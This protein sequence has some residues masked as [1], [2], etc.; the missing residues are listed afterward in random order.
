MRAG[1]PTLL[2]GALPFVAL[3]LAAGCHTNRPEQP[4]ERSPIIAPPPKAP[5]AP[6]AEGASATSADAETVDP[7]PLPEVDAEPNDSWRSAAPLKSDIEAQGRLVASDQ[8]WWVIEVPGPTLA[9][10]ELEGASDVDLVLEWMDPRTGHP[11]ARG[12]VQRGPGAETLERLKLRPP[13]AWLRVTEARGQVSRVPY[14]LLARL[15]PPSPGADAEP[16]DSARDA[17]PLQLGAR[18]QGT[19]GRVGDVDVWNID[20]DG[21]VHP[22]DAFRVDLGG[23]AGLRLRARAR[24]SSSQSPAAEAAGD[25]GR[26]VSLRRLAAPTNRTDALLVSVESRSGALPG[27]TYTLV[28]AREAPMAGRLGETEPNGSAELAQLVGA[29]G[30]LAG[31]L[32]APSDRDWYEISA[33]DTLQVLDLTLEPPLDRT[34]RAEVLDR[35]GQRLSTLDARRVAAS[36]RGVG[37]REGAYVVVSGEADAERPYGLEIRVAPLGEREA[38]PNDDRL[39][40]LV[41]PLRPGRTHRGWLASVEDRDYWRLDHKGGRAELRFEAPSGQAIKLVL[42]REDGGLLGSR[43]ATAADGEVRWTHTLDPGVYYVRVSA[44][45]ESEPASA[46]EP[47]TLSRH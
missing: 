5:A 41:Q 34:L 40:P 44:R 11:I 2:L 15:S 1:R 3:A 27:G 45:G 18:G 31:F 42:Y 43:E 37:I 46:R 8:D 33:E 47:Y 9:T 20:L 30:D 13:R 10:I 25:E 7:S 22:N 14:T 32:H 38:E 36:V 24:W 39:A 28:A 26:G 35:R 29:E 19:I 23:V 21:E 12:D 4:P 17:V 16:N 6:D